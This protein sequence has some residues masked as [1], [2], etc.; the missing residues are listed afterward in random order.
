[1]T[2]SS[3]GGTQSK[4]LLSLN[5]VLGGKVADSE[6][7]MRYLFQ[8]TAI[9]IRANNAETPGRKGVGPQLS[10][11]PWLV[12]PI[13]LELLIE[14]WSASWRLSESFWFKKSCSSMKPNLFGSGD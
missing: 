10:A 6:I 3:A 4:G 8:R 11:V 13:M 9:F 5:E 12:K 2:G 14:F 1:M 7:P